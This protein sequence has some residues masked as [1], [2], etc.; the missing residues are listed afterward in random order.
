MWDEI[1]RYIMEHPDSLEDYFYD[2]V[3]GKKRLARLFDAVSK[4]SPVLIFRLLAGE[5]C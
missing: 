2:P 4:R 3:E 1:E 5:P